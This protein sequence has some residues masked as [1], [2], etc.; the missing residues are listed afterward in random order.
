MGDMLLEGR[1]QTLSEYLMSGNW[2]CCRPSGLVLSSCPV[3]RRLRLCSS[4]HS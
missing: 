4:R 1:H 3:A 2:R